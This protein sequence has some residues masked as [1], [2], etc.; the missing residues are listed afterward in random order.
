M[1]ERKKSATGAN[2]TQSLIS[3]SFTLSRTAT[4]NDGLKR[5]LRRVAT[6]VG[7]VWGRRVKDML[8]DTF[9]FLI[10]LIY[11]YKISLYFYF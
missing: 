5:L 3:T 1:H 6:K 7:K 2:T 8:L 11:K 9:L 10:I 4:K